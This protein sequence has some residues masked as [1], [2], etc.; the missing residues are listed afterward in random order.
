MQ[1]IEILG[2]GVDPVDKDALFSTVAEYIEQK[3]TRTIAYVNIHVLNS[4]V[5][6]LA[7][8]HFLKQADLC[9]CDGSG[10]R[11]GARLLGKTLPERMTGADWI[12]DLAA[13][14]AGRWRIFW[15]GGAP[16]ITAKAAQT[17][18][19]AHPNLHIDTDHGYYPKD[20]PENDA[21]I[22][23]INAAHP[24]IVLV[25]MGTPLQEAWVMAHRHRLQAP[26]V[27]VLGA[28]ADFISGSVSRGPRVLYQ[29][30][31]W[32]ARLIT[33]PRRLWRRY[34]IGNTVFLLRV[35]RQRLQ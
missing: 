33:E 31:E 12:H 23:R 21:L 25:G 10:V 20:G 24:D 16:G 35:A 14:A 18:Q 28:T 17:L 5:H 34:L 30:Q 11:L 9:Y 3:Q 6:D 13:L 22:A 2:V 7:L 29:N 19:T 15:L 27:W 4:A 8:Q 32:L 1:R 26:V